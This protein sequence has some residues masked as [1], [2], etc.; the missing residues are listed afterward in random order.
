MSFSDLIRLEELT[1]QEAVPNK[2]TTSKLEI[3]SSSFWF[4]L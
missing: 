1:T 2:S 3:S 4:L